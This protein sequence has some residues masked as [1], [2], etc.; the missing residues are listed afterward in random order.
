MAEDDTLKDILG[1]LANVSLILT[2][3]GCS[4]SYRGLWCMGWSLRY[5]ILFCLRM[6]VLIHGF[7]HKK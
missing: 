7:I 2:K 6:E 3:E 5:R 4:K 1:A